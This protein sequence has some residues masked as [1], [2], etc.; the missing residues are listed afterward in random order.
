MADRTQ[1][2]LKVMNVQKILGAIGQVRAKWRARTI[3][4][5]SRFFCPQNER[6]FWQLPNGRFSWRYGFEA[7]VRQFPQFCLFSTHKNA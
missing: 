3:D 5:R 4:P 6:T 7:T 1:N 2:F